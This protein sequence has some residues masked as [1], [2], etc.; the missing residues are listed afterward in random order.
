MVENQCVSIDIIQSQA[1]IE[2]ETAKATKKIAEISHSSQN[3][4]SA[5]FVLLNR[6]SFQ[7]SEHPEPNSEEDDHS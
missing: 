4:I 1:A 5:N 6:H 7:H 2:D 3:I